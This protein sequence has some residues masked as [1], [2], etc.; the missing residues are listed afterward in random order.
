[1]SFICSDRRPTFKDNLYATVNRRNKFL[2]TPIFLI[3]TDIVYLNALAGLF[4]QEWGYTH[5]VFY[6][7]ELPS[8]DTKIAASKKESDRLIEQEKSNN[9]NTLA[10][11]K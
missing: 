7:S 5:D 6:S 8:K 3:T 4:L 1:M 10:A 11:A 9:K 2:W